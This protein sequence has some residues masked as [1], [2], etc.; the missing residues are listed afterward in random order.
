MV[1][2]D[3]LV[4]ASYNVHINQGIFR[5]LTWREKA[6]ISLLILR[7]ILIC[8]NINIRQILAT[9]SPVWN[10]GGGPQTPL[11]VAYQRTHRTHCYCINHVSIFKGNLASLEICHPTWAQWWSLCTQSALSTKVSA[12]RSLYWNRTSALWLPGLVS[13]WAATWKTMRTA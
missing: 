8:L 13:F 11:I 5:T 1:T 2:G 9:P 4:S 3:T 12:A 7:Q 10:S 6:N